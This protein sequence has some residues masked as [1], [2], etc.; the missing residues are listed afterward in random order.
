MKKDHTK[1]KNKMEKDFNG[2]KNFFYQLEEQFHQVE[3]E[4][5]IEKEEPQG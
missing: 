2:F 3:S 4:K 1:L 5:K